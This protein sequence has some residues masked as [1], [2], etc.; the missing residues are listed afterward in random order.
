MTKSDRT[1]LLDTSVQIDRVKMPSRRALLDV[2]IGVYRSS[3]STSIALLEFKAVMIQECVTIYNQLCRS[4]DRFTV[5]RDALLEKNHRQSRLRAHIFNNLLQ[6]FARP[7]PITEDED[8]RLARKAKLSLENQIPRLY[9]WFLKESAS[10]IVWD[11]IDCTRAKEAPVKRK[12]A[13]DALLP[14]CRIGF[15]RSCRI[16]ALI[17]EDESKA[18]GAGLP[19]PDVSEQLAKT[20]ALFA[21][22]GARSDEYL[23]REQC[24]SAGDALIALEGKHEAHEAM[25]S[26]VAEWE[27]L[28]RAVGLTFVPAKYPSEKSRKA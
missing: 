19:G 4:G 18:L 6:V 8:R 28:A 22:V 27:H 17:R 15:N 13:F 14:K 24:R 5:A 21:E 3:I 20:K 25:S 26:N 11:R 2:Q 7:G 9:A 10:E 16:E 1:V 12:K 23:S